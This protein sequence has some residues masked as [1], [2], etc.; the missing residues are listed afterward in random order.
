[1]DETVWDLI[2]DERLSLARMLDGLPGVRWSTPSLCT[3]WSVQDVLAHL[4]MTPAGEPHP[5]VMTR[6]FVGARGHLWRAGRDLAVSYA[7][8]DPQ[9][10]L[11]ALRETADARTKPMFVV[12]RN[13]LL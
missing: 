2:R 11:A 7:R 5:W 13:I 6:A 8:R 4:V 3:E 12:S 10:L 1:M 9:E